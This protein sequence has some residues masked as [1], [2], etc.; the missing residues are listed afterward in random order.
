MGYK[1]SDLA[2][3]ALKENISKVLE[4]LKLILMI[5]ILKIYVNLQL[6]LYTMYR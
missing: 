6:K 3:E 4:E 1:L 5:S 2:I